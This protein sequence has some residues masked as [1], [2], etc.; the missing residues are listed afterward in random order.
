METNISSSNGNSNKGKAA[1][2]VTISVCVVA[3]AG[4]I[5]FGVMVHRKRSLQNMPAV[6]KA[7]PM[8]HIF[9]PPDEKVTDHQVHVGPEKDLDGNEPENVELV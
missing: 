9:V 6:E 2:A 7:V 5:F 3:L 1:F 8:D 4:T